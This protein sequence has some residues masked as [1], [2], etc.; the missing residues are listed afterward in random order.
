MASQ[1]TLRPIWSAPMSRATTSVAPCAK[2]VPAPAL[3]PRQRGGGGLHQI[4]HEA[5]QHVARADDQQPR[6][7][8]GQVVEQPRQPVGEG[9]QPERLRGRGD[10]EQQHHPVH[11]AA[12]H[13]A[14]SFGRCA[15]AIG[16]CRAPP[17]RPAGPHR[18][19]WPRAAGAPGPS[20]RA[21]APRAPSSCGRCPSSRS[22]VPLPA[23]TRA[24]EKFAIVGMLLRCVSGRQ[25]KPLVAQ[26]ARSIFSPAFFLLLRGGTRRG[27]HDPTIRLE[28]SLM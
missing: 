15:S 10:E 24:S 16:P 7:Q 12:Q 25:P 28:L 26:A 18:A 22:K 21:P 2:R 4:G 1:V 6:G 9:L 20:R 27:L 14:P 8:R 17:G 13:R 11:D 23:R 3:R 19:G 5:R